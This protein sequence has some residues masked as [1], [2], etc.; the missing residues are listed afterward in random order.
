[1]CEQFNLRNTFRVKSD[2]KLPLSS[3]SIVVPILFYS[4]FKRIN[5]SSG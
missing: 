5:Y 4:L 1:M 3:W 2:P